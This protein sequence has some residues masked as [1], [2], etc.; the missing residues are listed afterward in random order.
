M[1]YICEKPLLADAENT[2]RQSNKV[3][4]WGKSDDRWTCLQ[5]FS[6]ETHL[7]LIYCFFVFLSSAEVQTH[8]QHGQNCRALV[9]SQ[10]STDVVTNQSRFLE[11][12]N[13]M[14]RINQHSCV[15]ETC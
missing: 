1:L 15:Y 12:T 13:K 5:V 8:T 3:Q 10:Q 11:K 7:M 4:K 2:I 9:Q 14:S 6:K